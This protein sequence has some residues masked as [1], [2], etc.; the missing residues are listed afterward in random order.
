MA[1]IGGLRLSTLANG[2]LAFMLYATAFIGGWVEQIGAMLRNET[3]VDL[4]IVAGL[5]M[6]ADVLW[7]KASLY[8]QPGLQTAVQFAGPF[9]VMSQPGRAMT[10]YATTLLLLAL[11]SFSRRDL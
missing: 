9:V 2:S 1:A 11:W 4:G 10:A 3:A 6:P 7:K 8:F 5:I